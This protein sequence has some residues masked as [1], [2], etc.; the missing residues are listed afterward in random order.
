MGA[1]RNLAVVED[2]P[3]GAAP[4]VFRH[5]FA[6]FLRDLAGR[7]ASGRGF[8]RG[9][10]TYMAPHAAV[11]VL[12]DADGE[13]CPFVF[14]FE[15]L[16]RDGKVDAL[17]SAHDALTHCVNLYPRAAGRLA[18]KYEERTGVYP[19]STLAIVQESWLRS[20]QGREMYRRR[21]AEEAERDARERPFLC[22]CGKRCKSQAGLTRHGSTACPLRHKVAPS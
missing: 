1:T 16:D 5:R 14:G 9:S 2:R 12:F 11:V 22:D 13:P 10:L 21:L 6:G 20:E 4:H 3:T 17:R 7:V 8:T 19:T 15:G 18:K